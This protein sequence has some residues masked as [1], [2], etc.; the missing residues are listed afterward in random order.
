MASTTSM[1]QSHTETL[2]KLTEK[3]TEQDITLTT[4]PTLEQSTSKKRYKQGNL[5]S[6]VMCK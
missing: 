4:T 3:K 1:L 2:I 6:Q 5:N